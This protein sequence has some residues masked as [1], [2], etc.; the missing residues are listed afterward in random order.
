MF[1]EVTSERR[2]RDLT[3][4]LTPGILLLGLLLR[5]QQFLYR[6]AMNMDEAFLAL[7]VVDRAYSIG[8]LRN[9]Y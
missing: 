9:A 2:K 7:N 5:G 3:P 6:H 8:K 1:M 4:F